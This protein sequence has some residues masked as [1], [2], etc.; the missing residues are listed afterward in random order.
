VP[1][2]RPAMQ[3]PSLARAPMSLVSRCESRLVAQ[4]LTSI[5]GKSDPLDIVASRMARNWRLQTPRPRPSSVG[6]IWVSH[7][8]DE[9]TDLIQWLGSDSPAAFTGRGDL[10]CA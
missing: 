6:R 7:P 2:S 3:I 5:E 8:P 4:G 9:L 1:L 10:K